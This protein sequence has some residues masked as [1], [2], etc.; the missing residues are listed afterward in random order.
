MQDWDD[1]VRA[2]V[3]RYAGRIEAYEIWNE[4]NSEQFYTGDLAT[5][6]IMQQHA[7]AIIKSVDPAATVLSPSFVGGGTRAL[8]RFLADGAGPYLDA[9]AV[10]L[11]PYPV[12]DPVPEMVG[13]WIDAYR[14][15]MTEFGIGN[16]PIWNTEF[17]WGENKYLPHA[18]DQAGYVAR[19]YLYNL[20]K[21]IARSYWYAYDND[22]W[23]T[24]RLAN[25]GN[26]GT[27]TAAGYAFKS[28][29]NWTVGAI[30][31]RPCARDA[32]GVWTCGLTRPGGYS[33]LIAWS[34]RGPSS[35]PAA[36]YDKYR[37][38][39]GE[40]VPIT[41]AVV[42]IGKMPVLLERP[43]A[44]HRRASVVRPVD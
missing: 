35:T 26:P 19:A 22:S 24:L 34:D 16:K 40:T 25:S 29:Y 23:G 5:M 37:D 42:P 43:A 14:S 33:A 13:P 4:V 36:G 10:H 44:R 30:M 39:A 2:L 15:Y 41:A 31:D 12:G 9:V 18:D 3:T 28:V 20:S 8:H 17:S 7:Y 6:K 11:Y 1:F 38:L 27:I 32:K 21:G